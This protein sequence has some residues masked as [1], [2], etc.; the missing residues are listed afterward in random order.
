MTTPADKP[1]G[2]IDELEAAHATTADVEAAPP[3][4]T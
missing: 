4:P 3:T 2:T 1:D